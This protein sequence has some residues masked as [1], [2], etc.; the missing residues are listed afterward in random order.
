MGTPLLPY[1]M[2]RPSGRVFS[3]AMLRPSVSRPMQR[4]HP[5]E[6]STGYI[7]MISLGEDAMSPFDSHDSSSSTAGSIGSISAMSL[8]EVGAKVRRGALSCGRIVGKLLRRTFVPQV[9][10][11]PPACPMDPAQHD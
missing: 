7:S 11:I 6:E 5:G 2:L 9:C 1:C 8:L 3:P 4:N 10:A